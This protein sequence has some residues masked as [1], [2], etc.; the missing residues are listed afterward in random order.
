MALRRE[1]L[2][3]A[4]ALFIQAV[5]ALSMGQGPGSELKQVGDSSGYR[6]DV[7]RGSRSEPRSGTSPREME[8]WDASGQS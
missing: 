8:G 7:T 1:G 5:R 6:H 3:P 2:V 4:E